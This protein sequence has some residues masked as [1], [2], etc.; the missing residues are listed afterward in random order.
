MEHS[1]D[2]CRTSL[3]VVFWLLAGTYALV[4]LFLAWDW[5]DLPDM[6]LTALAS[7]A[8]LMI[9]SFLSRFWWIAPCHTPRR[10]K[11][12]FALHILA[13]AT[14]MW[15]WICF[16]ET[17]LPVFA[18]ADGNAVS[19]STANALYYVRVLLA[20]ITITHI[21]NLL[22][23]G[24]HALCNVC[25]QSI[26][27]PASSFTLAPLAPLTLSSSYQPPAPTTT[28]RVAVENKSPSVS[29]YLTTSSPLR[30]SPDSAAYAVNS[31][32]DE[33][34]LQV[35]TDLSEPSSL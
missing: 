6:L 14:T 31:A 8:I 34:L 17:G 29:P 2:W 35:S 27:A 21:G 20:L 28:S 9:L 13:L 22:V 15:A 16:A 25:N 5:V 26:P 32:N 24:C 30:N 19:S 7:S 3:Y 4:R 11:I 18:A 10:V 33:P 12:S 23:C 1:D